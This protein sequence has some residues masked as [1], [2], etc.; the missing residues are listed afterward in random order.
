MFIQMCKS[1]I[2]NATIT[3]CELKY[4]GSI[5]IDEN[6]L[7]AAH[8]LVGEKVQVVNLNNGVRLET[9]TI[10]G[11]AGSGVVC[12]NGPAARLGYVGDKVHVI[13]YALLEHNEAKTFKLKLVRL[14]DRNRIK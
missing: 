12:L 13:S 9:Y 6:L 7:K 10:K 5:T 3:Q 4:E 2:A 11:K 1:K 8:I 14:D